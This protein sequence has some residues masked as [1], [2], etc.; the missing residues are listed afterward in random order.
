MINLPHFQNIYQ[1]SPQCYEWI[2][3]HLIHSAN[4]TQIVQ[5]LYQLG[6]HERDTVL[7]F[8]NEQYTEVIYFS[9]Q[10]Y[11]KKCLKN[12]IIIYKGQVKSTQVLKDRSSL[13]NLYSANFG[14]SNRILCLHNGHKSKSCGKINQI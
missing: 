9:T 1:M 12:G 13:R 5:L 6:T 3:T 10:N 11:R 2:P 4:K 8:Y 14:E 7:P